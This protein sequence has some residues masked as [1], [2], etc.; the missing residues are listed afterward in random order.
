MLDVLFKICKIM[1]PEKKKKPPNSM[2]VLPYDMCVWVFAI[3]TVFKGSVCW[4]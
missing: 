2:E 3:L 4:F 1:L